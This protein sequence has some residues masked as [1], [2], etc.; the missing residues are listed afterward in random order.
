MADP[1]HL[2]LNVL[3][4]VEAN[5]EVYPRHMAKNERQIIEYLSPDF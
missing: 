5:N 1:A 4:M 2:R 3:A